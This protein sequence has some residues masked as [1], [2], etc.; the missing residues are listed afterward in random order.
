MKTT[1]FFNNLNKHSTIVARAT[2]EMHNCYIAIKNTSRNGNIT[3]NINITYFILKILLLN[4]R[5]RY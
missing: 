5:T 4:G 1:R 3:S 2:E